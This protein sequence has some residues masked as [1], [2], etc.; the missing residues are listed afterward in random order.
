[1][2]RRHKEQHRI[3]RIGWLRA[4]VL[5][6]NDGI[7]STA[8]LVLGVAASSAPHSNVVIAA[9]A[10]LVGGAMSMATG[11]Y[12]SVSSQLDTEKA[13][14]NEERA[15][16]AEDEQGERRELTAIYV[17]RGLD[18]KLARQ[19]AEQLMAHNALQAHARDELVISEVTT[20]RPLQAAVASAASFALGAA[21]P[22]LVVLAT[23][24][25]YL[26]AAVVCAATASLA[27]LGGLAAKTGGAPVIPGVLRITFWSLLAMGV[28][29][30]VGAIF[31]QLS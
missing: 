24:Q 26:I 25:K 23:P 20:A 27:F 9:I 7:I 2:P 6:A 5:G 22:L 14:L 15:E 19:V 28:T 4:A 31:G 11:E 3:E 30:A 12:V 18:F 13:A 1:M 17:R 10:A 21:L 29:A 16:L 8:S